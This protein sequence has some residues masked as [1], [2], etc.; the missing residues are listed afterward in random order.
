ML[1]LCKSKDLRPA[2]PIAP[3][4]DFSL[5][6]YL[7]VVKGAPDVLLPRCKFVL[8]P[9]GKEPTLLSVPVLQRIVA[10]QEQW[11]RDG[12]RVLLLAR[13]VVRAEEIPKEADPQAEE[14]ADLVES[15]R[16]DLIIVGLVGLIDPL[17][18]SIPD[19][20][21]TCR[22]AGIRFFVV[23]GSW[24][25]GTTLKAFGVADHVTGDHPT[26]SVAIAAQAGIVSNV[27][28]IHHVADLDSKEKLHNTDDTS[29]QS[30]VIN[31]SELDQLNS[32]QVEQLC[33]YEE[34][35][36]ART[37]PEQK[38]RIVHEFKRRECVVAMTGD[39]VN[40]APSLKAADCELSSPSASA[41]LC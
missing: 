34:I 11:S 29:R 40:D 22:R 24:F 1:K 20:V 36:F 7:L 16:D 28:R 2:A 12:Q 37:T 15:L 3:W 23:T 38:L 32:V 9:A 14:F 18:P 39:G 19:V 8:D 35:V 33:K 21:K 17:K 31:G 30:I 26:T 6:D 4:D 25:W 10:V 27:D 13:R 5:S 41:T